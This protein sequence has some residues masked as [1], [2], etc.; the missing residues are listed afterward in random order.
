MAEILSWPI[1]ELDPF[2]LSVR[3]QVT[4]VVFTICVRRTSTAASAAKLRGSAI[5]SAS[6]QSSC[7]TCAQQ[8]VARRAAYGENRAA[9]WGSRKIGDAFKNRARFWKTP[10]S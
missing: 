6:S 5:A 3:V 4:R 2:R 8:I 9:R 7:A 1:A 10:K